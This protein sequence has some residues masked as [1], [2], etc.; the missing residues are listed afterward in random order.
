MA[1]RPVPR[2]PPAPP[3][4]GDQPPRTPRHPSHEEEPAPEKPGEAVQAETAQQEPI[5]LLARTA[6]VAVGVTVAAASAT[7]RAVWA[8]L[9][10]EG[11]RIPDE[12]PLA[13]LVT[14]ATM[15]A[16][17]EAVSIVGTGVRAGWAIA[18]WSARPFASRGVRRV[19]RRTAE[20]WNE[21]WEATS[22]RSRDAATALVR[23]LAPAV[24]DA[25][26]EHVDL[27]AIV[28]DHVDVDA[29]VGSIDIDRIVNRLDV[30]AIVER[31]DPDAIV[32]RVDVERVVRRLDVVAMSR[33]VIEELGLLAL[34]RDASES[35]TSDAVDDLRLGAADADRFVARVVDRIL[36]RRTERAIGPVPERSGDQIP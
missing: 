12:P 20:A 34:I 22:E 16:A 13:A 4:G 3:S 24:V 14:G 8:T 19:A 33:E 9:G 36:R 15:G 32:A 1:V 7:T 35:V 27:T 31:I 10:R 18:K 11:D 5:E 26:L 6:L 28:R 23:E 21:R 30:D 29:V 2:H 25:T 17:I